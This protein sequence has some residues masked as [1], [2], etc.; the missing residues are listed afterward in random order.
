MAAVILGVWSAAAK[1]LKPVPKEERGLA[2]LSGLFLA[3]HL[4]AWIASLTLTSV[5]AS[6]V[7]LS[8]APLWSLVLGSLLRIDPFRLVQ[9]SSLVLSLTGIGI[10]GGDLGGDPG[11]AM[12]GALALLSGLAMGAYTLCA[13]KRGSGPGIETYALITCSCAALLLG[14]AALFTGQIGGPISPQSLGWVAAMAFG[15]QVI[16]HTTVTWAAGR[17]KAVTVGQMLLLE[18]LIASALAWVLFAEKVGPALWIGGAL[19]LVGAAVSLWGGNQADSP[20]PSN[21]ED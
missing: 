14:G 12:G 19:I 5:A 18:P 15:S 2:L 1:K 13:R 4:G 16:G 20:T 17:I 8:T 10:I 21:R 9:A 11:T 3:V 7:L 6:L